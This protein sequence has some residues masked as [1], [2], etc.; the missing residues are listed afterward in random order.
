MFYKKFK[1]EFDIS[2]FYKFKHFTVDSRGIIFFL[3][4]IKYATFENEK[5]I[6]HIYF[7]LKKYEK[8]GYARI[9]FLIRTRTLYFTE[10]LA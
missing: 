9:Y 2:Y 8:E 1:N 10:E 6:C 4:Y 5:S 7:V 3:L